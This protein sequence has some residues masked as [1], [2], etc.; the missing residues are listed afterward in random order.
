MGEVVKTQHGS[1]RLVTM[2]K[3]DDLL[4]RREAAAYLGRSVS[5]LERWERAGIGPKITVFGKRKM[6]LRR[7]LD[8]YR[9]KGEQHGHRPTGQR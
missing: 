1:A 3:P 9:R 2:S 7:D 8:D 6:Y 5:S 4:N